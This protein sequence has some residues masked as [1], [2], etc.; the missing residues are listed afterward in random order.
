MNEQGLT[1]DNYVT[2]KDSPRWFPRLNISLLTEISDEDNGFIPIPITNY[3]FRK[4]G[5]IK[6]PEKS[7]YIP[8]PGGNDLR[9][10]IHKDGYIQLVKG[11]CSPII[12]FEHITQVHQ[13]QNL[14]FIHTGVSL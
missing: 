11:I 2:H 14:Y 12:N 5:A 13:F 3:W 1:L 10:Y 7:L 6:D 8:C 4:L 9:F